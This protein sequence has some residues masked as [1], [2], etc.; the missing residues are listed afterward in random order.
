MMMWQ[1]NYIY[2][3]IRVKIVSG[4][5]PLKGLD[6]VPLYRKITAG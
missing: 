3:N 2:N 6:P 4:T 1:E 5:G